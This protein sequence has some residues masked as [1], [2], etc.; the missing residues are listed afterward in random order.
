MASTHEIERI[1][2]QVICDEFYF[3]FEQLCLNKK[4]HFDSYLGPSGLPEVVTLDGVTSKWRSAFL[5]DAVICNY[6]CQY[7]DQFS[8]RGFDHHLCLKQCV[9]RAIVHAQKEH[10]VPLCNDVLVDIN[11]PW[12]SFTDFLVTFRN[13]AH[14][15]KATKD[16]VKL[17]C[18]AFSPSRFAGLSLPDLL[19]YVVSKIWVSILNRCDLVTQD[20]IPSAAVDVLLY[21]L[22]PVNKV[23]ATLFE[24]KLQSAVMDPPPSVDIIVG[25]GVSVLVKTG[26]EIE[27][28]EICDVNDGN[29]VSLL[30]DSS[31]SGL[32]PLVSESE[33]SLI[34][35][36][37]STP[38]VE[39]SKDRTIISS[40]FH[41]SRK[42]VLSVDIVSIP[43]EQVT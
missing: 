37:L 26:D 18:A 8:R 27:Y 3:Q 28:Q 35:S 33:S 34:A 17:M 11:T 31:T 15:K 38:F 21:S 9:T 32:V 12:V 13:L 25:G 23:S 7:D 19:N 29:T 22:N 6:K 10:Y 4:V 41:D 5:L 24:R 36:S 2:W 43:S 39:N 30:N 42:V 40:T 16:K 1:S 14:S 20:L